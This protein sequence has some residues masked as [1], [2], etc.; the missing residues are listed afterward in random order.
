MKTG[1]LV[2]LES[3]IKE[4]NMDRSQSTGSFLGDLKK[5][6]KSGGASKMTKKVNILKQ[7]LYL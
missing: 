3:I 7:K 5:A 1:F 4:Q 2:N 6:I